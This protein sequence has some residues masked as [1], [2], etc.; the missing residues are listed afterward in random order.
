MI[1]MY[2]IKL[3]INSMEL[4]LFESILIQNGLLTWKWRT[5]FK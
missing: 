2:E 4:F 3:E 1:G 5:K